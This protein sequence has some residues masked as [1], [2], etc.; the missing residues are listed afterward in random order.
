MFRILLIEEWFPRSLF[1]KILSL[2]R[3]IQMKTQTLKNVQNVF[4]LGQ[5]PFDTWFVFMR[6]AIH[7]KQTT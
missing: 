6:P 3:A 1:D 4:H 7:Q 5:Q 2:T